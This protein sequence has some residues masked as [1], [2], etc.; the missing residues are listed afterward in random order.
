MTEGYEIVYGHR[1][2]EAVKRLCWNEIEAIVEELTD[3]QAMIQGLAENIQ[4]DDLDP[5]DEAKAYKR[6]QDDF[7]WSLRRIGKEVGKGKDQVK[8][9]LALLNEP[10]DIQNMV[11]RADRASQFDKENQDAITEFHVR[12]VR[13][14]GVSDGDKTEVLKKAAREGL[15]SAQTRKIAE[16]VKEAETPKQKEE[17]LKHEYDPYY[18]DKDRVWEEKIEKQSNKPNYKSLPEV[19]WILDYLKAWR[20]AVNRW[21]DAMV[22]MSP[23]AMRFTARRIGMFIDDLQKIKDELEKK[24]AVK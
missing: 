20:E 14:T 17:L 22:K 11:T 3:E 6:L 19:K 5:I 10:D 13:E 23:E 16:A 2:V 9:M 4:R 24:G 21:H 8:R 1:R 12:Q 15:T 7:G 18:H